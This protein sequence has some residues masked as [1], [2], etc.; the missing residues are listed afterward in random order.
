[1]AFISPVAEN[2][3]YLSLAHRDSTN[4]SNCATFESPLSAA[5]II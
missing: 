1:M 2:S 3:L 4:K 5:R